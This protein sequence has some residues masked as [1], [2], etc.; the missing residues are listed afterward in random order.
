MP[1]AVDVEDGVQDGA[2]VVLGW[3]ADVE[4]ACAAF[5][6]PG[7]Q[8]WLD[9]GPSGVGQVAGIRSRL[10]HFFGVLPD[11]AAGQ[12]AVRPSIKR[13]RSAAFWDEAGSF[14]ARWA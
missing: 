9:E 10:R 2:Q 14:R 8:V 12:T 13:G 11:E 4:G 7:D 6:A 3:P 1:G 5:G